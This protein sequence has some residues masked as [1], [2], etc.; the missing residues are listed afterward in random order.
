MDK[1]ISEESIRN[2]LEKVKHPAID[3]SLLDLGIIKKIAIEDGKVAITMALP[4]PNIPIIDQLI[5]SIREPIDKLGIKIEVK[6]TIMNQDELQKF[7][8]IEQEGWKGTM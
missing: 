6:Q 7:L 5:S 1:N 2:M 8:T 3:R 4:F